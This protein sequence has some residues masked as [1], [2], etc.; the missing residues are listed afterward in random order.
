MGPY[1]LGK[2][3]SAVDLYMSSQIVFGFMTKQ[4]SH[5]PILDD[6]VERCTKRPACDRYMEQT[7]RLI[8]NLT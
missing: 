4:L 2:E 5:K 6:Y 1:I 8:A 3:F 7:N